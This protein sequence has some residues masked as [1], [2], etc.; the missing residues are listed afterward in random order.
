MTRQN[1][2]R[3][4]QVSI[5]RVRPAEYP[6]FPYDPD[7]SYPESSRLGLGTD[8]TNRVYCAVRNILV[9]MGLDADRIGSMEWDPL[10]DFAAPGNRVVVKPNWVLHANQDDGSIESLISHTSVIRAVIDYLILALRGDG[11]IEIVDAPLQNCDF[12]ELVRRSMID[13]LVEDY[14]RRF[15]GVTFSVL[16]LRKTILHVGE[17]GLPGVARQSTRLGDP[18]GYTLVDLGQESLLA[19]ISERFRRFRVANYDHRPMHE[20]H[21]HV[22]HEY[23]VANTVLYADFVVNVPKLKFHIKAGITGAL[24]NLVGIN[25]HKEYLPHHTN[26]APDTGGDQYARKS[27]F[28]PIVN[29]IYDHYWMNVNRGGQVGNVLQTGTIRALKKL[30][31]VV[32]GDRMYDG[33]WI[34]NDTIPRTTLDLNN[35]LYFFDCDTGTLADAPLRKVLHIVDGVVA[36]DGYGPLRPSAIGAGVVMAGWNPLAIDLCGARLMGLD[37]WK[38]RLLSYGLR[39]PKCLLSSA[40]SLVNGLRVTDDGAEV[41]LSDVDELG[42]RIPKEWEAAMLSDRPGFSRDTCSSELSRH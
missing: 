17:D 10:G 21:N 26:G 42:F 11:A 33:A 14:R 29:R 40:F 19:E 22:K 16:D 37:P 2:I 34:G 35:A 28:R 25:G 36:G 41:S 13:D 38:V 6:Q 39:N 30:V 12:G 5:R 8:R 3:N 20:H 23:L 31:A 9:D 7:Q 15:S 32:E 4:C 24:K 18:L 1:D 27:Y